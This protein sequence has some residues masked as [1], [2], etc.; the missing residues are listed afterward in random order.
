MKRLNIVV[1][2]QA[3]ETYI[4]EVLSLHLAQFDVGAVAR[5]VEFSRR[6]QRIVSRGGL[7]DY[8]KLKR[9]VTNWLKQ[10]REALVTTMV[11]LY[12]L[13]SDFPK[14]GE[15]KKITNP[16]QKVALLESAFAEDVDSRRFI[17]N[18][19]L[20]EFEALLFVD[21]A[22]LRAYY[23]DYSREIAN[24]KA[25]TARY[26]NPEEINEGTATAPSKRILKY[27]PIYDKVIGGSLMA[28]DLGLQAI[29]SRCQHFHQWLMRLEALA[30]PT[31]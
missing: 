26:A 10:D 25:E 16:F 20:H 9:D 7:F 5:R 2:G 19:Q 17:P 12:H 3:E 8:P 15:A 29:R 14:R 23:P 13:P 27:V 30:P 4:N 18:I 1:E 28:I 24:L 21:I 6:K 31:P 11:D 22:R